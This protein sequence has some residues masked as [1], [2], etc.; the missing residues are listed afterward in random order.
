MGP[1]C[2][3][4]ESGKVNGAG[5]TVQQV[6]ALATKLDG[7]DFIPGPHTVEGENQLPKVVL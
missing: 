1:S 2:K 7:L 6:R 5:E 4:E 3:G